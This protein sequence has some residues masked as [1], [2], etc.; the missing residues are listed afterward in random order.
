M[1]RCVFAFFNSFKGLSFLFR[2]SSLLFL[3][4]VFGCSRMQWRVRVPGRERQESPRAS[5]LGDL[6]YS[7]IGD[8][9]RHCAFSFPPGVLF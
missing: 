7:V 9:V 6:R 1:V 8:S 4:L 5:L 3:V 2:V